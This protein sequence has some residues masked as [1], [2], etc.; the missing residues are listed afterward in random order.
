MKAH[1]VYSSLICIALALVL[2]GV[3]LAQDKNDK[4]MAWRPV[5]SE[6]LA[7]KTPKV[8]PGADAEAI[9]W[10]VRLDDSSDSKLVYSHYVRV[11]IFTERGRERFS[12]MD[13]PFGKGKKVENVAARVTKPDGTV[14]ELKPS[15]IFEREIVK[16]GKEK[17]LAKSFAVPGIEPGVIVEYRYT[18]KL[19]DDSASGERLWFQRDIP[20]QKVVYYVRPH[21][22]TSLSFH[23][24]NMEDTRFLEGEKKYRVATMYDVPALKDEPFMPPDDE[25]RR[26]VYLRYQSLGTLFQWSFVTDGWTE[27]LK[28]KS[29]PNKEV[30]AKATELTAGAQTDEE[31]LKRIYE[32]VQKDIKNISYD[33]TM[34]DEAKRSWM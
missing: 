19:E 32:F 9:F 23:P 17:V 8:E 27:E 21:D 20:M 4:N 11:K 1:Q 12:K 7:M 2:A 6:E 13:I 28:K 5:T 29:K 33:K 25:V 3:A 24:Y 16:A 18:E 22:G 31:K 10:E 34:S 30:K 14:I 15:D 26:W